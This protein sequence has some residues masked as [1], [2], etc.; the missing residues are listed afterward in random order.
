MTSV[1]TRVVV[2]VVRAAA[3]AAAARLLL[4]LCCRQEGMNSLD[5]GCACAGACWYVPSSGWRCNHF[6]GEKRGICV[7]P[8][9]KY[10]SVRL[11][12]LPHRNSSALP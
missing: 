3:A 12:T 4:A 8:P 2:V 11:V 1:R 5:W 7:A 10:P 9:V 6:M